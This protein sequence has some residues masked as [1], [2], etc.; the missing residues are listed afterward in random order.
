MNN[1]V[2]IAMMIGSTKSTLGLVRTSLETITKNIG[3]SNF[4]ITVGIHPG[5]SEDIKLYV[6]KLSQNLS[7]N[8]NLIQNFNGS[9]AQFINLVIDRSSGYKW[10]LISHDDVNL[11]TLNFLS[12]VEEKVSKLTEPIGWISFT[13]EDYLNGSLSMSTRPGFHSDFLYENAW[14][15]RKLFQF[16]SLPENWWKKKTNIK[17]FANLPY[18]FPSG[19]VKCHAPFSHF[20]LIE[21][22]KLRQI[23]KCVDWSPVSLLIDEDW[24][25]R[26]L[27]Q[28]LFN[29]WIPNIKYIHC[30][31]K[32]GTR[33]GHQIR[34]YRKQVNKLFLEKWGFPPLVRKETHKIVKK[35][36][37]STNILWSCGKKSFEWEYV[38]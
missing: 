2:S 29:V 17:Y 35:L 12:M 38:R 30:R 25:L 4:L 9:W 33:A 7:K 1:S 3:T 11:L 16:H 6:K 23:G 5:I 10:F 20:V 8:I 19:V 24:G 18:D 22:K 32:T 14:N 15:R 36:Y 37:P 21:V 34:R 13:D 31:Q 27:Q 28:N 26:A